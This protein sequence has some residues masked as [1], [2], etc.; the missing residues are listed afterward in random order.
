MSATALAISSEGGLSISSTGSLSG[1]GTVVGD[2]LNA[3]QLAPGSSTGTLA[4]TGAYSQTVA[5]TLEIE[6]AG[7][8]AGEFDQLQVTGTATLAGTLDLSILAPYVPQNLDQFEILSAGI[9]QNTF[10]TVSGLDFG[11][12]GG[13]QFAVIDNPQNVT[14]YA[15]LGGDTDL[16]GDVD[17]AD[18]TTVFQNFTG[19]GGTG[20][21][22]A[23]GD[24]D[25]DGDVD[26]ADTTTAFQNFTGAQSPELGVGSPSVAD[27]IY[28]A[29]TGVLTIDPD[30]V[31]NIISYVLQTN[32]S[33]GFIEENHNPAGGLWN[34]FVDSTDSQI[35][36]TIGLFGESPINSPVRIGA[37]M[38]SGLTEAQFTA[39]LSTAE[40][41]IVGGGGA[42][43]LVWVP[44]PSS[45]LLMLMGGFGLIV[46]G[47][48][49]RR[50]R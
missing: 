46:C 29:A 6:F 15:A 17:T 2:V 18:T 48:Q 3:G 8:G 42:F 26:T 44:E 47:W 35:G 45:V 41:A 27:L 12:S 43:D 23:L 40:W 21:N 50:R 5:G 37:V 49:N 1:S 24:T 30:G 7:T 31:S 10:D 36:A 28:D 39:F 14:V 22:W 19:A 4:I 32:E 25:H 9:R 34:Q 38:P 20:K 16:D 13:L 11:A 33:P